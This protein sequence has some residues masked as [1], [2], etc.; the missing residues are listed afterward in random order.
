MLMYKQK[1]SKLARVA[2]AAS[3]TA[4]LVAGSVVPA[5]AAEGPQP[6]NSSEPVSR[7]VT[8]G[9]PAGPVVE[10][11]AVVAAKEALKKAKEAHADADAWLNSM[12]KN[13]KDVGTAQEAEVTRLNG[14]IEATEATINGDMSLDERKAALDKIA[15]L[16][17][18]IESAHK[19]VQEAAKK[20]DEARSNKLAAEKAVK[21]AEEALANAEKGA[22][23]V[24]AELPKKEA[25]QAAETGMTE[26]PKMTDSKMAD[27]KK[28]DKKA[29][30]QVKGK[31]PKTGDASAIM[32]VVATLGTAVLGFGAAAKGKRN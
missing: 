27:A 18:Q 28:D 23:A 7:N 11:P 30:K 10:S 20:L 2:V 13:Y 25:G 1:P 8:V 17:K 29:A 15:G 31:L 12:L 21:A 19:T 24:N 9:Q 6:T 3:T 22:P 5:F 32:G 26:E 14:E 16:K 4:V